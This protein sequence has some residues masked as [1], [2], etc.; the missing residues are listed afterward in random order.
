MLL[1]SALRIASVVHHTRQ[2]GIPATAFPRH[3]PVQVRSHA[4]FRLRFRCGLV[5]AMAKAAH[6]I[7][8][9]PTLNKNDFAQNL[10]LKALKVQAK[11]CQSLMKNFAG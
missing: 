10:N 11:Q 6:A 4:H 9:I 2:C 1:W 8:D 3:P 5:G 7:A